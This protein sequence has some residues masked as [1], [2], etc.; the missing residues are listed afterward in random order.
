MPNHTRQI[1]LPPY[2]GQNLFPILQQTILVRFTDKGILAGRTNRSVVLKSWL[3]INLKEKRH[4]AFLKVHKAASST[5]QNILYRFGYERDLSFALPLA[6]HIISETAQAYRRLLPPFD[7]KTGRYDILCNHAIFNKDKFKSLMYNDAFYLAIVRE[8]FS[9][10]ISAV[11]YYSQVYHF[12]YLVKAKKGTFL[13]GI[14]S[15][16]LMYEPEDLSASQTYNRMAM[17][18]GLTVNSVNSIRKLD[19]VTIERFITKL[20]E[21]FDFVMIVEKFDESLVIL[22]RQLKW[23]TKD[24]LYIKRN[25]FASKH[26]RY[27]L[28]AANVT[29]EEKNIFKRENHIDYLIYET[30]LERFWNLISSEK[31]FHEEVRD[32]KRKLH[33]VEAFCLQDNTRGETV[34]PETKFNNRFRVNRHDCEL[35]TLTELKFFRKLKEKHKRH[36]NIQQKGR[37]IYP[38]YFNAS[39]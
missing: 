29:E 13:H 33:L 21:T 36:C 28:V 2:Q 20:K 27:G 34:F 15:N 7:K 35:L 3:T 16:P 22:K 9:R 38:K 30:F 1:L 17:D 6:G 31:D 25:E 8:P 14:I 39:N 26:H 19:E 23:S 32:F 10:F 24:I 11:L 4:I 12:R 5:M 37:E 18:F